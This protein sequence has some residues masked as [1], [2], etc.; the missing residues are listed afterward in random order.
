ALIAHLHSQRIEEHDRVERIQRSS[1][2]AVDIL[3]YRIGDRGDQ[4][5]GGLDPVEL[6]QVPLDVPYAHA[7]GVH[8]DDLVV[9]SGA[10]PLVFGDQLRLKGATTIP[11]DLQVH[12]AGIGDDG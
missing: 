3:E 11:R 5:R 9:E 10:T 8:G 1:L 12:L 2:P 7:A 4:L 6:A